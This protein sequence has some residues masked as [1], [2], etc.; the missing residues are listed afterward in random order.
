MMD[1]CRQYFNHH[2]NKLYD[3]SCD[4][5]IENYS[6]LKFTNWLFNGK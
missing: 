4:S 1:E 2:D 5:K 3:D 6:P